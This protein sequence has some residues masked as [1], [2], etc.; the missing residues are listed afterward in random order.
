MDNLVS[1][2]EHRITSCAK[3]N[4]RN[5]FTAFALLILSVFSSAATAIAV[6]IDELPKSFVSALAATPGIFILINSTFRFE[7]RSRWYWKKR[8]RLEILLRRHKFEGLPEAKVSE[9]WNEIDEEMFHEWP[10]FGSGQSATR[11]NNDKH[12]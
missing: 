4:R 7:E 10:G 5:Y 1:S 3:R 11:S 8:N 9:R 12:V 6:A 2:I